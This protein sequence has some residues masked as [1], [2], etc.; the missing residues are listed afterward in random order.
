MVGTGKERPKLKIPYYPDEDS[1]GHYDVNTAEEKIVSEYTGYDFDRLGE[2][3]VFEFWLFL[4]DAVVYNLQQTEDGR[5]YLENCWR[6]EQTKPD[7]AGLH[8]H[9]KRN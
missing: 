8:S 1:K 9:Y 3:S 5:K 2:L 4:R 7:R 6:I